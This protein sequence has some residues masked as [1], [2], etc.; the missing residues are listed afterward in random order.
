[1]KE[2]C[3][4]IPIL[5]LPLP[6]RNWDLA[7]GKDG[8]NRAKERLRDVPSPWQAEVGLGDL[9]EEQQKLTAFDFSSSA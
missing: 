4:D 9:L 5:L 6:K 8:Q 3:K 7:A 2:I 1:M